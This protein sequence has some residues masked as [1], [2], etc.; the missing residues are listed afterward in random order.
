MAAANGRTG[1][2]L[3]ASLLREPYRFEFFQA[4]RLLEA[5][6][7]VV[8]L[9]GSAAACAWPAVGGARRR[10][11]PAGARG[12]AVPGGAVAGL[13]PGRGR[14]DPPASRRRLPERIAPPPPLEMVVSFLGLTGPSGALPHHY[15]TLLLRRARQGL[16]AS[17]EFLD[18]FNH[19]AASLFHRAWEKYRL[20]AA[21]ELRAW[22][23]PTGDRPDH[24]G[25]VLPGGLGTAG[26]A[27]PPGSGRRG[28]SFLRRPLFPRHAARF[29][30]ARDSRR[31]LPFA[32]AGA[33]IR[34]CGCRWRWRT[35]PTSPRRTRPRG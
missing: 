17:R 15:T 14:R 32:G 21:Y 13:R 24:A 22:T 6:K 28:L 29:G 18:L 2:G 26:P 5:G 20:A 19:R 35:A 1:S 10:R 4:V 16:F 25:V 9:D 7:V 31:L 23:P 30:A 12:R 33:A 3:N 11:R 34:G 27:R 8:S